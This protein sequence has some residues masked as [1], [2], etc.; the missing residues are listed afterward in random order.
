MPGIKGAI[1]DTMRTT[2]EVAVNPVKDEFGKM[3]ETGVQ[4]ITGNYPDPT[5]LQ[6][7]KEENLKKLKYANDV[8]NW[9]GSIEQAQKQVQQTAFQKKTQQAQEAEAKKVKQF[10]IEEVKARS[11]KKIQLEREKTKAERK[12]GLGG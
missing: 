2:N 10:Q 6:K 3:V 4:S 12:S 8:I 11:V 7:K 9:Y 5:K 1:T